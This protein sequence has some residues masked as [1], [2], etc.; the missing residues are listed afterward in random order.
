MTERHLTQEDIHA[1]LDGESTVAEQEMVENHLA[2][3]AECAREAEDFR[4]IKNMLAGL[5]DVELPR[6]FTLPAEYAKTAPLQSPASPTSGGGSNIRRF[7]PVARILSIAAVVAFLVLGG[8]Q[9]AG[10]FGD[11]SDSS[12]DISLETETE[13][14][15]AALNV[16]DSAPAR[17]EL[18]EQGDSAATGA[19]PLTTEVANV[20]TPA[21]VDNGLTPLEITTIGIGIVALAAIASW[22]LIH[23]RAG[24]V[25]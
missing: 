10:V 25:S 11:E 17:G 23:Y 8:G 19:G 12:S 20:E 2:A 13:A 16:Q 1:W 4:A 5:G 6:S 14:P 7:E 24:T 9:L 22:I 15:A 18:R 3:C 21:Q